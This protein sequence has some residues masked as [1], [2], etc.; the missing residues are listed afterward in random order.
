MAKTIPQ[1]PIAAKSEGKTQP[2]KCG[3]TAAHKQ[4]WT[5]STRSSKKSLENLHR[6][7]NGE[8]IDSHSVHEGK[9]VANSH[10]SV[11]NT[12]DIT[13]SDQERK[14]GKREQ[15]FYMNERKKISQ[16]SN[17]REKGEPTK[18]RNNGSWILLSQP[19]WGNWTVALERVQS[20]REWD[21]GCSGF[22]SSK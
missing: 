18:P 10:S 4:P 6:H 3:K 9:D 8:G 1:Q 5:H 16:T 17:P 19:T 14:K 21:R 20:W 7:K 22:P 12:Q 15:S 13:L 11:V 2:S